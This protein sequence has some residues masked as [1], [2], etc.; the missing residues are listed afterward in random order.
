MPLY[1]PRVLALAAALAFLGTFAT[2]I[3]H[4]IFYV[5][6]STVASIA[7]LKWS[8]AK[9]ASWL[10]MLFPSAFYIH[11]R[12]W[13]PRADALDLCR[14]TGS[15]VV[16]KAQILEIS[17]QPQFQ[18]KILV[19]RP[20]QLCYP[21]E[22]RLT[23][24][25]E[26]IVKGSLQPTLSIGSFLELKGQMIEPS[27]PDEPW[28]FK[29]KTRLAQASIFSIL[30]THGSG[31]SLL[32]ADADCTTEIANW[33]TASRKTI[34][35]LHVSTLGATYGPLLESI[36]L[37]NR[38]VELPADLVDKYRKVGLSHL[39]AAS[40]FNLTIVIVVMH[41]LA[42]SLTRSRTIR[43][44]SALIPMVI[45]VVLAGLSPSVVRAAVCSFIILIALQSGRSLNPAAVLSFVLIA[46][47]TIDPLSAVDVG[48]QLSY[49]ATF[50]ILNLARPLAD[51]LGSP[52]AAFSKKREAAHYLQWK[53]IRVPV[54]KTVQLLPDLAFW[55]LEATAVVLSAQAA[56]L[57]IQ[58][59]YFWR[60]GIMFLPACVL[61]DPLVAPITVIGF[62][63]SALILGTPLLH[64]LCQ[65]LDYL[66]LVPIRALDAIAS[67]FAAMEGTYLNLG[68]PS[69]AA[70]VFYYAALSLFYAAL[71]ARCFRAWSLVIL[72]IGS[73]AL[74]WRPGLER[75]LI[76]ITKNS[77]TFVGTDRCA[78]TIGELN[79]SATKFLAYNGAKVT[80][81]ADGGEP[82][83]NRPISFNLTNGTEQLKFMIVRANQISDLLNSTIPP[84]TTEYGPFRHLILTVYDQKIAG[85]RKWHGHS[86]STALLDQL[87][88]HFSADYVLLIQ[89]RFFKKH[90]GS[91]ELIE[92]SQPSLPEIHYCE[93]DDLGLAFYCEHGIGVQVAKQATL[94]H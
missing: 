28:R 65:Q 92:S 38:C 79:S 53:F 84:Q 50:G 76:S 31:I 78:I 75:P 35:D 69:P 22:G 82:T 34:T 12:L 10:L 44:L 32:N 57:P 40:G 77:L 46:V 29:Q 33:I 80:Y 55:T 4:G 16:F 67:F 47:L 24:K 30:I 64:G 52:I 23:G 26:V 94:L 72:A 88:R 6:A 2:F 7:L 81:K 85:A 15:T 68:P 71:T 70:I 45:F 73:F 62:A 13:Q 3:E 93:K 89:K 14:F 18:R 90:K 54:I 1:L 43:C 19:V 60:L 58:L 41:T 27:D 63:S 87:Q 36:V 9:P 42:K 66:A 86:I 59:S 56:V 49:A 11:A 39:L 17:E 51:F 61:V 20:F 8:D 83:S 48:A 91:H 74:L 25:T 5:L 21:H 37:G